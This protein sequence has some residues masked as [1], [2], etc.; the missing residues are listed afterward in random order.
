[1]QETAAQLSEQAGQALQSA[2]NGL[3]FM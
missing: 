2:Q 1:V 3:P